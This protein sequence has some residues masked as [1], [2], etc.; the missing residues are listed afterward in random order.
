LTFST[1][2]KKH[3]RPLLENLI[4]VADLNSRS[5]C[6]NEIVIPDEDFT[7]VKSDDILENDPYLEILKHTSF[8]LERLKTKLLTVWVDYL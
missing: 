5:A 8:T 3:I 7:V 6:V 1:Q 4:L 2:N